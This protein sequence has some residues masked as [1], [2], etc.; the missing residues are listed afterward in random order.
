MMLLARLGVALSAVIASW[1]LFALL[2]T[3]VGLAL[4]RRSSDTNTFS[5]GTSFWVG[6]AGVIALLQLWHL[7]LPVDGRAFIVVALISAAGLW[8][9]RAALGGWLRGLKQIA[10]SRWILIALALIWMAHHALGEPGIYDTGYYHVQ[11]I[12]WIRTYPIVPG[13]ANLHDRFGFNN[14]NFLY[15]AL[16]DLGPWKGQ[17]F[18]FANGL[19]LAVLCIQLILDLPERGRRPR[20]AQFFSALL[21]LPVVVAAR[22][23]GVTSP[24]PDLPIF[25]L[26]IV[27]VRMLLDM[28]CDKERKPTENGALFSVLLLCFVG[29]AIKLSF[30]AFAFAASGL[31]LGL[32]FARERSGLR[33]A[34]LQ[35]VV[36]GVLILGTWAGRGIILSGYPAYPS[37]IGGMPVEWRIPEKVANLQVFFIK[38]WAHFYTFS[39]GHY[40]ISRWPTVWFW[41]CLRNSN[42]G[43]PLAV[44]AAAG[45]M[46]LATRLWKRKSRSPRA[47]WWIFFP[48][49]V[50]LIYWGLSA[51]A[52]RFAGAAFWIIGCGAMA[53]ALE[54]ALPEEGTSTRR[55]W[56]NLKSAGCIGIIFLVAY[57]VIGNKGEFVRTLRETGSPVS[58]AKWLRVNLEFLNGHAFYPWFQPMPVT[59]LETF[60]TDSGLA[61]IV[62]VT[63]ELAWD[64]PLPS[65][66]VRRRGLQ[67]RGKTLREGF[68]VDWSGEL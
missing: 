13:L 7:I 37:T 20:V 33:K 64:A 41:G 24:T 9:H 2:F 6:W 40:D 19:L 4:R 61:V 59:E 56:L 44:L 22:G 25:V 67:L 10:V 42:V 52:P 62:P 68:V 45:V 17:Y 12:K 31:A 28:L 48:P 11:M 35:A 32:Q 30:V 38:R 49:A 26:G 46:A 51:P 57:G 47:K 60:V 29:V 63:G 18:H 39:P 5:P 8:R 55:R 43:I 34:L 3:G 14:A 15:A 66:P 58:A 1:G 27:I 54:A 23:N 21:L 65:S 16:L 53:F 36:L 50:W